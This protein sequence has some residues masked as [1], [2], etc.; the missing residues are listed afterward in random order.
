MTLALTRAM[1]IL[2]ASILILG[3]VLHATGFP[4]ATIEASGLSAFHV[5]AYAAMW[6]SDSLAQFT[7]GLILVFLSS[8]RNDSSRTV[9][10]LLTLI[11]AG[12]A[13]VVYLFLG[14][15]FGGHLLVAASVAMIAGVVCD[16]LAQKA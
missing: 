15:F 4:R 2:A 12:I 5:N 13:V 9:V 3:S 14:S 11:P 7:V 16:R 1:Y 10:V 8:R 6:F